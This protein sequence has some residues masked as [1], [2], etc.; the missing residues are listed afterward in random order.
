MAEETLITG[1]PDFV[2]VGTQRSGTT[3]WQRL[4]KSHP[5]I[6]TPR[7]RKKE[8]HFFDK[9]GKRPMTDA[10]VARYHDQFPRAPG[11]L[12]G[13][14]TPRY[15][16]DVWGPRVVKRAAPDAK[17]LVMF[18]DPVERYR[19]GVLHTSSRKPG[20]KWEWLSTDA[21]ERGRYAEQL[22]RLYDYFDPEQVLVLQYEQCTQDP[23]H[24][25]SQTLEFIGA[26]A[27]VPK[28]LTRT[29]GT[30]TRSR[31]EPIW[32]DLSEAIVRELEEDVLELSEL[33]PHLD[34][35]LW[36]NFAHL[37]EGR[38]RPR[39]EPPAAA[40]TRTA[41]G[42]PPDFVGLGTSHSGW[43]WWHKLMLEHPDVVRPKGGRSLEFFETFCSRAMTDEDVAAYH[44]RFAR[45]EGKV[46]GEWSPDYVYE[47]WTPMLLKRAAPDAKLIV[48]LVDPVVRYSA[49]VAR[50]TREREEAD[51]VANSPNRGCYT[52]QLKRVL[53]F[54]D[55]DRVL[56]L[57][58][59]RCM[60]DPAG[61]YART[62]RFLG[63]DDGFAPDGLRQGTL[64]RARRVLGRGD[65]PAGA[66]RM[67][68]PDL[69]PDIEVPML[70]FL[71]SDV[72]G[73]REIVPELDLALWPDFAHLVEDTAR[74]PAPSHA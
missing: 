56:V 5:Q 26:P 37:A 46:V 28:D 13:E 65:A 39:S 55:R 43:N 68:R 38:R 34:V 64:D 4:L 59:E 24:H 74:E 51:I 23:L 19:S 12:A 45:A 36:K 69:W 31:R 30:P 52:R 35:S 73:L 72:R 27:H 18:R 61:E 3:W 57:Q 62:M 16:R 66:P 70:K 50:S 32:D 21:T 22:R 10:D 11:E 48:M 9:F 44:A 42:G 41:E 71:E 58:L 25:Y 14:W 8:Q 47:A 17:I 54:Y 1:P 60:R 6:R 2:G 20:L 40:P 29:R 67:T 63:V 33:V 7:N 15:M 53:E 49:D